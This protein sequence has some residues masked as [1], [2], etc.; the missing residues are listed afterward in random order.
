[1]FWDPE[2]YTH[3]WNFA[4]HAHNGQTVPGTDLP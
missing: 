4:A 2:I 1:M 3:T